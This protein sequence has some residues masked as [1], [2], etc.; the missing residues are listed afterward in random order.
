M[1]MVLRSSWLSAIVMAGAIS[2]AQAYH[3]TPPTASI[4]RGGR[5]SESIFA[6]K[7][8]SSSF[9]GLG[10][11]RRSLQLDRP[12]TNSL[13]LTS[14]PSGDENSVEWDVRTTKADDVDS[15]AVS[16]SAKSS[17]SF[18]QS[19]DKLGMKLKPLAT[20][21]HIKANDIKS[22]NVNGAATQ[23]GILKS[24]LYSMKSNML[25][26]LY[27]VYRGYRGFFVILPAVFREVFRQLEE[28]NVA[29]DAFG[30]G[31]SQVS[32]EQD[33]P[34]RLRTRFTISILS[35]ILTLSY[36]VSGSMR[37][38]GKLVLSKFAVSMRIIH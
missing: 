11:T 23:G 37:V 22:S 10:A 4:Y 12:P 18:L 28:S 6:F 7:I 27:I 16:E 14:F 1:K 38:M 3:V 15:S 21:A 19:I 26:M 25:W 5:S 36:V 9:S 24:L 31:D 32:I 13:Q 35:A 29:V 20:A 34:M 30:E 33:P 17:S 8:R 2:S